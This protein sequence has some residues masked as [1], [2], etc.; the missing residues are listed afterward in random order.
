[1][2][3]LSMKIIIHITNFGKIEKADIELGKFIVFVG[4]NNSGKT[5]LM[6]LIYGFIQKGF[7][8]NGF[9]IKI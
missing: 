1:M 6:Q 4:E 9:I 2:E 7:K 8:S 3:A 5:Y